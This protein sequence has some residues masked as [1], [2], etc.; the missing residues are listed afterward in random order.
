VGTR[1]GGRSL[2]LPANRLDAEPFLGEHQGQAVVGA[3]LVR[4]EEGS[5]PHQRTRRAELQIQRSAAVGV[6]GGNGTFGEGALQT[7]RKLHGARTH[8]HAREVELESVRWSGG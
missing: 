3:Q 5:E 4:L 6:D 1:T 2:A 7:I 8:A